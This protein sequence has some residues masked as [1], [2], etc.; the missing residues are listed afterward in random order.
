MKMNVLVSLGPI[1]VNGIAIIRILE[2]F[3]ESEHD[4]LATIPMT[5]RDYCFTG[6]PTK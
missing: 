3:K 5:K 6:R 1:N 4:P 2:A